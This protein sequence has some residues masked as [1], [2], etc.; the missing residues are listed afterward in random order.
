MLLVIVEADSAAHFNETTVIDVIYTS[1]T[2]D[3]EKS[4]GLLV[5]MRVAMI[6]EKKHL[7]LVGP[8]GDDSRPDSELTWN[9]SAEFNCDI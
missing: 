6:S 8:L 1:V 4:L 9:C 2:F 7:S 3:G 5:P